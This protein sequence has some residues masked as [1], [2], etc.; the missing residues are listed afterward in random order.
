MG[1][2]Y[3]TT[4]ELCATMN[5]LAR[6]AR[7]ADRSAWTTTAYLLGYP[8]M[9]VKGFKGKR[10][11]DVTQ[12]VNELYE[13]IENGSLDLEEIKESLKEKLGWVPWSEDYTE[14]EIIWRKGSCDWYIDKVQIPIQNKINKLASTYACLYFH[15]LLERKD[16]SKPD[17]NRIWDKYMDIL[18]V[19][20]N[21]KSVVNQFISELA[22]DAGIAFEPP[23]DP[24]NQKYGS[25]LLNC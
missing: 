18:K 16:I 24:I 25:V 10:L 17:C 15:V 23:R 20:Q 3:K 4:K 7:I 2:R 13:R 19:Y 5:R 9:I 1:K 11:N 21:D 6:E 12:K 8:T 14:D 22:D